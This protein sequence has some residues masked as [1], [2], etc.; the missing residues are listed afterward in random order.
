MTCILEGSPST[1]PWKNVLYVENEVHC[2]LSRQT[3][4]KRTE[5]TEELD[6]SKSWLSVTG[7]QV[8]PP[9]TDSLRISKPFSLNRQTDS[10]NVFLRI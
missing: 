6:S 9:G 1:S 5:R 2:T 8:V 7:C 10:G 3:P 4:Y